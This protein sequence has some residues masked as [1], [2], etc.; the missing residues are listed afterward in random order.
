MSENTTTQKTNQIIN[1]SLFAENTET[2]FKSVK[3]NIK[4]VQ[5][6]CL[7]ALEKIESNSVDCI[8]T[9]P[10]YF[11]DGM[12]NNWNLEKLQEKKDKAKVVGGLPVGMKFDPQQGKRLQEFMSIVAK[13]LLRVLK[14]GGFFLCFSQDRLYHR[15]VMAVEE[16]GF[17]IRDMLI[18]KKAGQAKAFSQDHFVKKMRISEKEKRVILN[19]LANRKTPQ[20]KSESEPIVLAQKPKEGTFINNWIRWK[21]GLINIDKSLN[22]NFPSTI[23][24]VKK[25]V[26]KERIINH[27]T[28]KPVKLIEYLT[29]I[30]SKENQVILDPFMGS[31]TTGIACLNTDRKFI[32]IEIND[33]Y[34]S[35]AENRL[36]KHK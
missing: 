1:I 9:D 12:E 14:P 16:V 31:G 35:L 36:K 17:E 33:Y 18:W 4:I 21:T 8:I 2:N 25:P 23:M 19:S 30:F 10:P 15:M 6:D 26:G 29:L 11:L 13:K 7:L 20:L 28:L 3:E 32:G 24:D 5:A 27:M 34:F 22:G